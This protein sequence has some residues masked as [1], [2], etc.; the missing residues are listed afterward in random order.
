[1][2]GNEILSA[3]KLP[4]IPGLLR[5]VESVHPDYTLYRYI[6][7]PYGG[8]VEGK[9]DF[10]RTFFSPR[11][12]V[13]PL[14][15][16]VDNFFD[17][18]LFPGI[19][20]EPLGR[21]LLTDEETAEGRIFHVLVD[22][23]RKYHDMIYNLYD[24]GILF[25]S[26]QAIASSYRVDPKTGEI[27]RFIPAEWSFTVTPSN[28]L[29]RPIS[30]VRSIARDI[31]IQNSFKEPEFNLWFASRGFGSM[32]TND[33]TLS[34]V[35]VAP[36]GVTEAA[37]APAAAVETPAPAAAVV[38]ETV[39]PEAAPARATVVERVQEVIQN[40]ESRVAVE[41]EGDQ[42]SRVIHNM[43]TVMRAMYDENHALVEL[44]RSIQEKQAAL[45]TA[46][47]TRLQQIED[48]IVQ[49]AEANLNMVSRALREEVVDSLLGVSE[50]ERK[51]Y[52]RRRDTGA[53][54]P[55]ATTTTVTAQ[56]PTVKVAP[57]GVI[58]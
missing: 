5:S 29:A 41:T 4:T 16:D 44:V 7:I 48:S 46:L 18:G 45:E 47:N 53:A 20:F 55:A 25:G 22:K 27:L 13:G 9:W 23:S 52:A 40:A 24:Q 36:P 26:A 15:R 19:D 43:A 32:E 3:L 38:T 31:F 57:P 28:L 39:T 14:G 17:H 35:A 50:E 1:M 37:P 8:L 49:S 10:H 2:E 54:T 51:I 6:G 12:D 34:T 56:I 33:T 21:A 11:T 42:N 58:N 30:V